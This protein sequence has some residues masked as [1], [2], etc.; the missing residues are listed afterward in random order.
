MNTNP[1][2]KVIKK[3]GTKQPWSDDKIIK[4]V[5]KSAKR[6]TVDLS[7]MQ[8]IKIVNGVAERI[9]SAGYSVEITVE[10]LHNFVE[11][12]LEEVAPKVAASY[13]N[14]RNFKNEYADM[15][16]SVFNKAQTIM[17]RGD[18]ENSNKDS[19]LVSTQKSLIGSAIMEEMYKHQFLTEEELNA[20]NEG[21]IYIHDKPDRLLTMNCCLFRMDKVLEGG[22][23]MGNIWYNEPKD[24]DVMFDVVSDVVLSAA[25]Q[26]YGGYTIPRVDSLIVPYA[27]KTYKA[28]YKKRLEEYKVL[29]ANE[30]AAK[31]LA[32]KI[33]MQEVERQMEQGFQGWEYKFNTVA[34]SRG[35]YPFIT[36]TSG[37]DRTEFGI[38]ANKV[39][40]RVHM[41]G[42]G[43]KGKK[44][45]VL[46]PKYVFL[47]DK[48]IHK[49]G[50]EVYE[51]ALA[52]SRKVMYPDWLS[53]T[54]EGYVPSMYKKYGQVI[55]P[56]GCRAFLSPYYERGGFEPA[57]ENDVPV[58]EGRFN[59]GAIS[60]N[61]PLIYIKATSEGKDFFTTLN[62]YLQM[63]RNLHIRT[64][65]FLGEKRA[66]TN[67]LGFC[68]GG[69]Y[70][71]NLKFNQKLKEN[72]KILEATTFSFGITALNELQMAYNGKSITEDGE[73][74]LEV[75]THINRKANEYK[76][77]D[78]IL[79]A[80]Y[81]TPAESLCGKQVE[82]MREYVKLH[83]EAIEAA[84]FKV[85]NTKNGEFVVKGVCDRPY[86]TNSFHCPVWEDISPIEK[87]DKENRFWN[88]MNGGKIQYVRYPVGYNKKAQETLI[89][90]AMDM[91][92]Y[93]GIN[94]ALN[95]CDD[96]GHEEVDMADKCPC[97]GSKNI[98][99][100]DR[101][102]GYLSFSRVKG[103][104]RLNAA[105]MAEIA[106]RKSM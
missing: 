16:D 46:F 99:K 10:Q 84:G 33:A 76:A 94:L 42:Q 15:L 28:I 44:K 32:H 98:T 57:D 55:S 21:F 23:E 49:P 80:L 81:G 70:G 66:S 62:Y 52:C 14:Y 78:H 9:L 63:I 100:I 87:Q 73:F 101:M 96:C 95:Y 47:F 39:M 105:K 3:N 24:L 68:E 93:E 17:F 26:Q 71:G 53:L 64:R 75:M 29:A 86:V 50:E 92:F 45:P 67:P 85:E 83:A 69:F 18:K 19:S 77:E 97:C 79:Y 60:L 25:S 65:D 6:A 1:N 82:Q 74:A 56:M 43:K 103:D 8:K 90:R 37:L 5:E 20:I 11:Q 61:L 54:G 102:N 104:S 89:N 51:A 58:F 88:L 59:A 31:E 30:D 35:D 22:F 13:E 106:E 34:S 40:F 7:D 12:S 2:L 41:N 72:P 48:Y 91:G 4:A 38:M 36:L 27:E